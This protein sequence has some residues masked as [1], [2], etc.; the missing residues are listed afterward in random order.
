MVRAYRTKGTKSES[1]IGVSYDTKGTKSEYTIGVSYD[2][3]MAYL[4]KF[5]SMEKIGP[6]RGD[7][8][9][10]Y[11]GST[12]DHLA[13]LSV[14]GSKRNI[15]RASF[16]FFLTTDLEASERN[17]LLL[18]RF[19]KNIAPEWNDDWL[20]A[21]LNRAISADA[22]SRTPP[23]TTEPKERTIVGDKLVEF[24]TVASPNIFMVTVSVKHKLD[25]TQ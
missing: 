5:V 3:V 9:D 6:F 25:S 24:S 15:S 23:K 11:V 10:K 13:I 17:C 1:K 7:T 22:L 4:D 14:S 8:C 2:Q 21:A 20:L 16:S 12:S 18:C 19:R